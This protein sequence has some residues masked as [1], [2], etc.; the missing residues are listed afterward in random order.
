MDL[1]EF[2]QKEVLRHFK[3]PKVCVSY[4]GI[5]H[6]LFREWKGKSLLVL[7]LAIGLPQYRIKI[8]H[9]DRFHKGMLDDLDENRRKLFTWYNE[10][11][12]LADIILCGSEFVKKTVLY[13]YPEFE[14]KCKILPYGASWKNSVFLKGYFNTEMI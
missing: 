2:W 11:V 12:E 1:N 3:P 7:D 6:L 10:E 14:N 9:G 5:S 8:M 4:D 13:F